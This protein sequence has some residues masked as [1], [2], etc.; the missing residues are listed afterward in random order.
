[1]DLLSPDCPVRYIITVNAL[2]EGWDCPFAYILASLANKTSQVDVEQILGRI[3]RLPYT[4]EHRAKALNMSYVLTSSNDFN[5]TVQQIIRGLNSAGFSDRDYRLAEPAEPAKPA[6]VPEQLP[7]IEP[8]APQDDFAGLNGKSIGAEL[9][10]RRESE[11]SPNPPRKRTVCLLRPS[12]R[13]THTIRRC[14]ARENDPFA[15]ALP[16][17]VRDKVNTFHIILNIRK[18][19][20]A[21]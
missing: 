14:R 9:Q 3:L 13:A 16:W 10:R 21:C 6:P 8:E 17:E 5:D 11:N 19:W 2:K 4:A 18:A 20:T 1:M 12:R 7:I 15:A